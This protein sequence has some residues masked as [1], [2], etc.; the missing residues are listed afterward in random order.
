MVS[1]RLPFAFRREA[2]GRWRA[3]PGAGGLVTALLPVLRH[4]GGT[5]IGWPGASESPSDLSE[6]LATVSEDAGYTLRGVAL[7]G[8]EV[9]GFYEGFANEVIWPLFHDLQSLCNFDPEYWRMY[10]TVNRKFAYVVREASSPEDF[11]WVHDYHLMNVAAE[12][13][14]RGARPA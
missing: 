6:E 2:T 1:N 12:L 11:I 10:C 13:R 3:V 8:D 5:W 9:H 14:R 7:T 4:R